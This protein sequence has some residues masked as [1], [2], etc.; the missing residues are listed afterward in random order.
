MPFKSDGLNLDLG[1]HG[2][3]SS[4]LTM[5]LVPILSG[6]NGGGSTLQA[7][8]TLYSEEQTKIEVYIYNTP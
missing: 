4:M 3:I 5:A 1:L 2:F 8:P 7:M 6:R